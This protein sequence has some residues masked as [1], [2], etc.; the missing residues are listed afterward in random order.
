[1]ATARTTAPVTG[2][3]AS[4]KRVLDQPLTS[5]HLVAGSSGLLLVLGLM[6]VLSASSV[7]SLET[8]GSSYSIFI[9]QAVWVGIGLPLAFVAYRLPRRALRVL[10]WPAVLVSILLTALTFV[11]GLGVAVNGNTNWLSFGGPLQIQ[12]AELAK[13][14]LVL[15][16]ADTYAR[17]Q[18]LLTEWRH[19]LMPMG[20]VSA[21]VVGL[22]IAQ[23][24]LGTALVL[25]AIVLG[26]LWVIG[27]PMRLFGGAFLAVGVL[28]FMLA[29]T[30]AERMER[31]TTFLDPVSDLGNTGYQA[32][33]GFFALASGGLWGKGIGASNQKWGYLPDA[34]TDF[35][36]A[37]IGE[38]LGL[39]GTLVVLGLFLT[40]AF[41]GIRVAMRAQDRFV[42]YAAAGIVV[43]ILGQVIINVGMVLGLLPVIGVPLPLLSYGGSALIPT[44]VA[45]ALLMSFARQEPEAAA[46][47]RARRRER[48]ATRSS[49]S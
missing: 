8:T 48:S 2:V 23:G 14:G 43:W 20:L 19:V 17:K 10:A 16:L 22:V 4:L 41:G 13:L 7:E 47:L 11:P 46:Y 39:F 42:R 45:L 34:H 40:L 33:H 9:R 37:I 1:M 25:F 28:A 44:M 3:R 18:K 26:L 21:V 38:E 27:V 24:D 32:G 12:P 30:H 36:F 29:V 35:I 15:W 49:A 31:L 5:Y 6:M